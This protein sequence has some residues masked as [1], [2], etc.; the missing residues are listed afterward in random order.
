[1]DTV[2]SLADGRLVGTHYGFYN[3]IVGVGILVGNLATGSVLQ[4][5]KSLGHPELVW[6]LLSAI[7]LISA[8]ALHRLD[9]AGRLEMASAAQDVTSP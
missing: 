9:R 6:V 3:T 8:W 4:A 2:V 1:M 5:A 7:G